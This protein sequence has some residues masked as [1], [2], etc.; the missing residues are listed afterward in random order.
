MRVMSANHQT[1]RERPLK[2][3]KY[4]VKSVFIFW[5]IKILGKKKSDKFC[6]TMVSILFLKIQS[7]Y[8]WSR[9]QASVEQGL[10]LYT[11][12]V[13]IIFIVFYLNA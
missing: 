11:L 6:R 10:S 4:A 1:S 12:I 13:F 2:V 9:Q 5:V 3:L 8:N 7:K